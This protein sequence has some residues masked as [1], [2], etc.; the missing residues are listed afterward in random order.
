[1]RPLHIYVETSVFGFKFDIITSE[2]VILY[3]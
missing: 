3:G 1:M 2:E